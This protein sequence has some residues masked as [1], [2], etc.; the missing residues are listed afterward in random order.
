MGVVKSGKGWLVKLN[1][2]GV[3]IQKYFK[4][5]VLAE[6][7]YLELKKKQELARKEKHT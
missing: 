2:Q 5:K 3:T 7:V 4:N 6:A 1:I